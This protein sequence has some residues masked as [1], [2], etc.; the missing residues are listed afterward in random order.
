L[1]PQSAPSTRTGEAGTD[2]QQQQQQQHG[3]LR[4]FEGLLFQPDKPTLTQLGVLGLLL[5][6]DPRKCLAGTGD[7]SLNEHNMC[8]VADHALAWLT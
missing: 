6:S 1:L 8:H 7:H 3:L 4:R 5:Q 2:I